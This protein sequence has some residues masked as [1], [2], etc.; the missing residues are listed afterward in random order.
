MTACR[1][2]LTARSGL[3]TLPEGPCYNQG[4]DGR[5]GRPFL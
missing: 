1:L 2:P 3:V 4:G 5:R